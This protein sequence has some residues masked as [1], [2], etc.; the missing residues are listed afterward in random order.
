MSNVQ[1]ARAVKTIA[2]H[3]DCSIEANVTGESWYVGPT[4][5]RRRFMAGL[6]VTFANLLEDG[7]DWEIF[8]IPRWHFERLCDIMKSTKET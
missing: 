2:H 3:V 4:E 5:L 7:S 6:N 8:P 1:V